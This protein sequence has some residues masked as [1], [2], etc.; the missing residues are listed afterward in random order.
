MQTGLDRNE[1]NV[2][3]MLRF[4]ILMGVAVILILSIAS[5]WAPTE[6]SF[7]AFVN[8]LGTG[9]LIG[10]ACFTTGGLMGFLFAI[11]KLLQNTS[12]LPESAASNKVIFLHND[13]L[14]QISDWLTKIIVGVGLTQ[15]HDIP[16]ALFSIGGQLSPSFGYG[17]VG[18]NIAVGCVLYFI[19]VGF[20]SVYIWTRLYFIKLLR[21]SNEELEAEIVTL[22]QERQTMKEVQNKT[23]E[24]KITIE[25][26]KEKLA[27][28]NK[29]S[30]GREEAA[31]LNQ[32]NAPIAIGP[33]TVPDDPQKGRF[34]GRSENNGR[35]LSATVTAAQD[36]W[37]KIILWVESTDP[38]RPL[39]SEVVF[40]L[41]DSF[42]PSVFTIPPQDFKNGKAE[43]D[44]I[45]AWGAFTVGA[46]TDNGQ[47]L[48]E[49]DLAELPDAPKTF[50]ER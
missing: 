36:D 19:V 12:L 41:H 30:A 37:F 14:V 10:G 46:V 32:I 39:N 23:L 40:Y 26:Q 29:L 1:P 27:A 48:L 9:L 49:L 33:V 43:D 44:E 50:R 45:L 31:V 38:N 11:P 21:R 20:L 24:E 4:M 5:I 13:N 7:R 3:R 17:E 22:K 47:T 2:W 35:K 15:L 8:S 25:K 34:G 28:Q 6:N 42:R 16:P 18:R